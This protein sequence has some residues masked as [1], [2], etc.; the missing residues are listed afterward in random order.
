[1]LTLP[2]TMTF[3]DGTSK[4]LLLECGNPRIGTMDLADPDFVL[5]CEFFGCYVVWTDEYSGYCHSPWTA[6]HK[7]L[8]CYEI[9][10]GKDAL[11]FRFF[12]RYARVAERAQRSKG[13][14]AVES[15]F[16][17][18]E[19]LAKLKE[20]HLLLWQ[21]YCWLHDEK[22]R[23]G[24]SNN[25]LL[26]AFLQQTGGDFDTLVTQLTESMKLALEASPS[27]G[28]YGDS[29]D[30]SIETRPMCLQLPGAKDRDEE[31]R[32]KRE[33]Y[34]KKTN[35]DQAIA[36]GVDPVQH[37]K[38]LAAID[39]GD[40]P[41]G[42]FHATGDQLQLINIEF[43][44]WEKAFNRAG[45]QEVLEK[46]AQNASRRTTYERNITPYI[47]F[48]FKIEK[49][50]D[51]HTIPKRSKR[52][53]TH[54]APW[55]AMPKFVNSA[56]ELEMTEA[57]GETAKQRSALTPVADNLHRTITVPYA[58][59]CVSGVRTTY[60]YSQDYQ[61]FEEG[62]I[63]RE[64]NSPILRDFEPKLNGCD[65]YGLM[66]Y[67][68]SGTAQNTGYPAF[69]IILERRKAETFVHFHRVHPSRLREG[70]RIQACR[71]VEECYRYMAGNVRAE[72]I[73]VQQGDLIFIKT[74]HCPP[75]PASH[76]VAE[77]ES[78]GFE[79]LDNRP[80]ILIP[81]QSKSVKNRL[82]YL[83][84]EGRFRVN[85]PE[86]EAIPELAA[87]TYEVRRAKSF[88]ANPVAV[89]SYTVD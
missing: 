2:V 74:E 42:V 77:F 67:T 32:S 38:L 58:A 11:W 51:R 44:L 5:K 71:L 69:L 35:K 3:E 56:W 66:Y 54:E 52:G 14:K 85:H 60:C 83:T 73:T 48:L 41:V 34:L 47:A 24:V 15:R 31:R 40:I 17:A 33:W 53:S 82:G 55:Q 76:A 75:D 20:S 72:E 57:E 21:Y 87:G 88:E 59:L 1:M 25:S 39:S 79:P 6:T 22:V 4:E 12:E 23:D 29:Y 30:N 81:N 43:D 50:L 45:W 61:V 10:Q 49:Y 80:V 68:L 26:A 9:K 65:D 27:E 37:P 78:H 84:C 46:I 8:N 7:A 64:S 16:P 13:V 86:H 19:M 36:L 28:G 89:W 63:D 62:E 70:K 18:K